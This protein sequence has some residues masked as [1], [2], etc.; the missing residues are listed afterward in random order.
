MDLA[1]SSANRRAAITRFS[2]ATKS[3]TRNHPP[4]PLSQSTSNCF[5]H[6]GQS[7]ASRRGTTSSEKERFPGTWKNAASALAVRP[8]HPEAYLLLG[9]IA[10]EAGDF[11]QAKCCANLARALCP[12]WKPAQQLLKGISSQAR[13]KSVEWPTLPAIPTNPRVSVCLITKNEE[14][15][16]GHCLKSVREIAHQIVVLDTG[17]TDRTIE[18]AKE[19]TAEVHSSVWRDDFSAARNAALEHCTGDWILILDAD[20]ELTPEGRLQL[21]HELKAPEV[22]IDS[23]HR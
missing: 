21:L 20:E 19:Y 4:T 16:I 12:D 7:W 17:S 13:G 18:I 1:T 6:C 5:A 15:F 3:P 9:N 11:E 22:S 10:R 23:H 8:F 14:Q 2:H